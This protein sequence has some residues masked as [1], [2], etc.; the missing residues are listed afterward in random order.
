MKQVLFL[1]HTIFE[2]GVVVD[3]SKVA[4]LMESKQ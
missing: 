3:L 4:I 2:D 1:R